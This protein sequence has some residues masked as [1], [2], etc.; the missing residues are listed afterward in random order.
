VIKN[1]RYDTGRLPTHFAIDGHLKEEKENRNTHFKKTVLVR[2][3][4]R[5]ALGQ[6]LTQND[7]LI[8]TNSL[9]KHRGVAIRKELHLLLSEKFQFFFL[10]T[11]LTTGKNKHQWIGHEGICP[12]RDPS[13]KPS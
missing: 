2:K 5:T 1:H 10:A 9:Q 3:M 13:A 11:P 7:F 4:N 8:K 12:S 6:I